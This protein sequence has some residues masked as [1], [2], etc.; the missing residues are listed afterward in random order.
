[1][2]RLGLAISSRSGLGPRAFAEY[3]RQAE[4]RGFEAV[5]A[6]ESAS[7]SLAL[8]QAMAAAT[9]RI[10]VGTAI[11]NIYLRHPVLMA[12]TA[13]TIDELSDGRLL[14]GLGTASTGLNEGM[15]GLA[16]EPPLKRMREYLAV[17]RAVFAGQP[18]TF[19]GEIFHIRNFA[20][21]RKP[22]RAGIP[23]YV[24]ALLP[25]MTRL[26]G[27]LA[28]GLLLNVVTVEQ[29]ARLASEAR[30]GAA[31]GFRVGALAPCCVGGDGA[32]AARAARET[33]LA[34]A[35]HPAIS[36]LHSAGPFALEM[37]GVRQ[38]LAEGDRSR[39]A[40]HVSDGLADAMV[41]HG[42]VERCGDRLQDYRAAGVDVPVVLPVAIDGDWEGSIGAAIDA[43]GS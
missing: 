12:M 6:T 25:R 32:R 11:A 5:F 3:A 21:Q 15:L 34:Y 30:A 24:G 14:L 23:I 20:P 38:A 2:N 16:P 1:V 7:D 9:E 4:A 18:V 36:Q 31:P 42:A 39:A 10:T 19:E 37:A 8:V 35:P 27:E 41:L 17:L 43:F 33:V 40:A 22:P 29:A 26:A 13:A 28:D